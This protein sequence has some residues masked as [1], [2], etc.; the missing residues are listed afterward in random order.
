[1]A[2]RSLFNRRSDDADVIP[3]VSD[4]DLLSWGLDLLTV[5]PTEP[6]ALRTDRPERPLRAAPPPPR[7]IRVRPL[8]ATVAD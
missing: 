8:R 3:Q 4:D 5:S 1:M 6:M 7:R 2:R